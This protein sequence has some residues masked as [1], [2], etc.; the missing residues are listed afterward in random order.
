MINEL[1]CDGRTKILQK[2][3]SSASARKMLH[4]FR[5]LLIVEKYAAFATARM[6]SLAF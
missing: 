1:Q 3:K 2:R 5:A 4:F 6:L